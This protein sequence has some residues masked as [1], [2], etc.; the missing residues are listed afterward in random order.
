MA[1]NCIF[2]GEELGAFSGKKLNCAGYAENV[3]ADCYNK[4]RELDGIERA[5]AI[6]DTGRAAHAEGI[7]EYLNDR[8]RSEQK[9]RERAKQEEEEFSSK[10]PETGKC[11]KCG[12]P[13]LQYGPLLIKLGE[14]SVLFSDL[15]RLMAGSL[16]VRADRCRECGYTE[17]YT[18]NEEE[19]L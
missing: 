11:P 14:E 9:A 5:H 15:R 2:C 1:K 8:I 19:L 4:Y 13:L 10:H 16:T 6:L 12:G 7:R 3:C 17:F 18:P